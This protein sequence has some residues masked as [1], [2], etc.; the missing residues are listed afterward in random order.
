M[1]ASVNRPK[2]V[3]VHQLYVPTKSSQEAVGYDVRAYITDLCTEEHLLDAASMAW[4]SSNEHAVVVDGVKTAITDSCLKEK[5]LGQCGTFIYP[6]E[7]RLVSCGF[8]IQTPVCMM[9][10]P[11]SGLACKYGL[12]LSNSPGIVDPDYRGDIKVCLF[13]T[14]SLPIFI[15]DK[16]RVAQALFI[17][18]L[19]VGT[20]IEV[21]TLDPTERDH[22]GFGSTGIR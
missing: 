9:L 5:V 6:Q 16:D 4:S 2:V 21:E 10:V 8:Q 15:R 14:G 19:S 18:T 17:Y 12:T 11:R 3:A 7:R 22:A 20:L 1:L 13:N